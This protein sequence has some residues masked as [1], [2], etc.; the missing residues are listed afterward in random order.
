MKKEELIRIFSSIPTLNTERLTLR[1]MSVRDADDMHDYS[2]RGELTKYLLWSPHRN[3]SYTREY[4][5]YIEQ[6]YRLGD[7]YDWAV[8]QK[9]SGKMIGTCGFT[10]IDLQNRTGELGYVINP[11]YHSLG[12]APEAARAVMAFGFDALELN[13]IEVRFMK[14]NEASLKVARK[15]G[16]TFEGY[17]RD[18]MLVKGRYVTVGIASILRGEW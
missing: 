9:E 13:R 4:L 7:F 16:M 5:K 3:L 12:Y 18:M 2:R 17:M 1:A 15:L 10:R 8:I 14:E 11:D 6:R